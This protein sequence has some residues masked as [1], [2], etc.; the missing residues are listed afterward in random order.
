MKQG[1]LFKDAP[2]PRME[3]FCA[4][5]KDIDNYKGG[6]CYLQF[7]DVRSFEKHQLEVHKQVYIEKKY[8]SHKEYFWYLEKYLDRDNTPTFKQINFKLPSRPSRRWKITVKEYVNLENKKCW[9]GKTKKEFVGRQQKYCTPAHTSNW[10]DRTTYVNWHKD[11]FLVMHPKCYKCGDTE[12][13]AKGGYGK[14]NLEV[15]HIIAIMFGGH[16]WDDRN[17]QTLCHKCHVLKTNSDRR[18]QKFWRDTQ[19]YDPVFARDIA[20]QILC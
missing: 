9:C 3:L 2:E 19:Y 6:H 20:Q 18:I 12:L 13:H 17:L 1:L 7:N 5:L 14:S 15:D 16:P 8:R 11:A 10:Y 4:S